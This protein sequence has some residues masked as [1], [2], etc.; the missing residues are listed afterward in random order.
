[1]SNNYYLEVGKASDLKNWKDRAIF[2]TFEIFPGALSWGALCLAVLLS[3]KQPL[4]VAVFII[5]LSFFWFF[6]TIYFSIHLWAGYK[7][8]AEHEKI[9]WVEKLNG[10]KIENCKLKIANWPPRT[11]VH[12]RLLFDAFLFAVTIDCAT[13]LHN[14]VHSSNS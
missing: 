13:T 2:R 6:R 14:C 9:N 5:L 3:W 10:L 1:M 11:I 4:L 7:R 8:M 12:Q